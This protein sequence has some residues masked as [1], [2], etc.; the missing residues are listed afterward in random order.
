MSGPVFCR[1]LDINNCSNLLSAGV[2]LFSGEE[3]QSPME[4]E[5]VGYHGNMEEKSMSG[6]I[7][8]GAPPKG[9]EKRIRRREARRVQHNKPNFQYKDYTLHCCSKL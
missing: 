1:S 9:R 2:I 8:D 6:L 3:L 5:I 4:L 7:R